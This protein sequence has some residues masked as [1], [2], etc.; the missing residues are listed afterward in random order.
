MQ[1]AGCFYRTLL[2]NPLLSLLMW[3]GSVKVYV[4]P[5]FAESFRDDTG[6]KHALDTG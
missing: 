6:G 5:T 3:K 2:R 4:G 1:A